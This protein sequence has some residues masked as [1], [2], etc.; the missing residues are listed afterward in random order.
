MSSS[1]AIGKGILENYKIGQPIGQG[2]YAVVHICVHK[3][4]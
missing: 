1:S 2:A 3:P 4:S